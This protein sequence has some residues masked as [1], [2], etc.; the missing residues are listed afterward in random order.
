MIN[1]YNSN[2]SSKDRMEKILKCDEESIKL[3]SE[4]IK[5]GG[6]IVYPT[7][8]VYGLGADPYNKDA[9]EKIFSIK[10]RDKT[11]PLPLL[12]SS[13]KHVNRIVDINS[14]AKR[15]AERFWP[16]ALTIIMELKDEELIDILDIDK[17]AVRIPNNSCALKLIDAC[18]GILIGTS[19]NI[20]GYKSIKD[21][22]ELDT[23]LLERVDIVIDDGIT[24]GIES[25]IID[26]IDKKIIRE[27]YLKKEQ[28]E[29]VLG[30][31]L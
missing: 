2:I 6:I 17:G 13:L 15:L 9:I 1:R 24:L 8:T 27:G 10:E 12:C 16:G 26:I 23:R 19:A 25:T 29:E 18:N 11:K 4:Y 5:N 20:S 14:D 21:V 28:L 7:D 30:Y 3:A 22:R 31:E